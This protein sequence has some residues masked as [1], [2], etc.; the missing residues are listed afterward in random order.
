[1]NAVIAEEGF[2]LNEQGRASLRRLVNHDAVI[3]GLIF[4][5]DKNNSGWRITPIR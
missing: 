5:Y 1:V 2:E 3:K 4:R